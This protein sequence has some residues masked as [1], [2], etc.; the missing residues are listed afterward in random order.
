MTITPP[1][2]Q[3]GT[4]APGPSTALSV[5]VLIFGLVIGVVGVVKAVAPLVRTLGSSPEFA[6]PQTASLRLSSGDYIVYERTGSGFSLSGGA[7]T[8]TP[9]DVVVTA[10]DGRRLAVRFASDSERI[11]RNGDAYEGAVRFST[12]EAGRYELHITGSAGRVIVARSLEDTIR[13][14]L[15]W[16]GVA[17]LGGAVAV[18]GLVMWIV[19]GARRRRLRNQYAYAV[20]AAA[21][22]AWY[23]DPQ[24][25]GRLRYWDGTTWTEH[26]HSHTPSAADPP[27]AR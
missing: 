14:G 12:P 19:G 10:P 1:A 9:A 15:P 8:L 26:V 17:L 24:Q 7:T 4:R 23:P 22:P 18:A 20:P 27:R 2:R 11:T 25:P 5:V 16:W 3:P 6:T 21:P 13:A